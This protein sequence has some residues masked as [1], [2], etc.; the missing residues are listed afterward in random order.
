MLREVHGW[1]AEFA[2]IKGLTIDKPDV[3]NILTLSQNG[4]VL[5]LDG[6]PLVNGHVDANWKGGLLPFPDNCMSIVPLKME[7]LI[8]MAEQRRC[9]E[10]GLLREMIQSPEIKAALSDQGVTH[11]DVF[12]LHTVKLMRKGA[13]TVAA[14][15][16]DDCHVKML[17][18]YLPAT[19]SMPDAIYSPS[20]IYK[21]K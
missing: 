1:C 9:Y 15:F 19:A 17:T 18:R 2:P 12:Q 16:R 10:E 14:W 6:Q 5:G 20:E 4:K 13:E 3:P 8:T 21:D 7:E 11:D